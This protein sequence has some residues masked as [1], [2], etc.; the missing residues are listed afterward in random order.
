M[1]KYIKNSIIEIFKNIYE[2]HN[3][4]RELINKKEYEN[5]KK[6]LINCEKAALQIGSAIEKSEGKDFV[7][8]GIIE[9]YCKYI[10]QI[11][12]NIYDESSGDEIKKEADSRLKR[13]EKS[14]HN[15]IR[16]RLEIVFAPY[17]ASMWDS[18]ES[19]WKA[20]DADP[21]CDAYVVPVPYYDKDPDQSFR[22]FHYEGAEFPE[23]VP[24]VNY[25]EYDFAVRRPD[26]IY[27]HNPYDDCNYMTSVSP[28]FYSDRL[29][30]YTGCL[31]YIPYFIA[32]RFS[33]PDNYVIA[34]TPGAFYSDLIVLQSETLKRIYLLNGID[35]KK[36]IVSGSPKTD[37]VINNRVND[38]PESW[39]R[40]KERKV[41]LI[42]S[43]ISGFLE[44]DNFILL[45]KNTISLLLKEEKYSVLWRPHPLLHSAINSMRPEKIRE[46]VSFCDWFSDQ[47]YCVM[48]VLS[49]SKYAIDFSDI[50][51]SDYSSLIFSYIPTEKPVIEF[52]NDIE[53]S[54]EDTVF[55][56]DVRNVYYF[57]YACELPENLVGLINK[58]FKDDFMKRKRMMFY[59]KSMVNCDG[60]CGLKTHQLIKKRIG[61]M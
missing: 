14:V 5:V 28:E 32:G 12:M 25:N 54:F 22:K 24:V 55:A 30:Q 19:V 36:I 50:L 38:F 26:I 37:A 1:R 52:L 43:S 23:Y 3:V 47:D 15:D 48:D 61:G 53:V 18:L 11:F 10:Y 57:N 7:S 9:E 49:D 6:L 41:C 16:E 59:K 35:S 20:A 60:T 45:L 39:L 51:L 8:V 13:A 46:Y 40:L 42:N 33:E 21:D 2:L 31:V 56:C 58:I 34:R 27:I 4:L 44:W 17:K 29:K